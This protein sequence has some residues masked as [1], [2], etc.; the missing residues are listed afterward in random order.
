L[1]DDPLLMPRPTNDDERRAARRKLLLELRTKHRAEWDKLIAGI[2][3]GDDKP[4][5]AKKLGLLAC[6]ALRTRVDFDMAQEPF[7][8]IFWGLPEDEIESQKEKCQRLSDAGVKVFND[9]VA[10]GAEGVGQKASTAQQ[11]YRAA[12]HADI[13]W[14]CYRE[15]L[16]VNAWIAVADKN[17]TAV[18]AVADTLTANDKAD[19]MDAAVA[20]AFLAAAELEGK[21]ARFRQK[22]IAESEAKQKQ[23]DAEQ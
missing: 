1:K 4:G 14:F 15:Y 20:R 18:R 17:T 16:P 21:A 6:Q 9:I 8:D 22:D 19:K 5:L 23:R 13:A 12:E 10:A 3:A 11:W 7:E 2:E